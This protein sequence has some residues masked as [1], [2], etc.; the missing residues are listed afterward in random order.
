MKLTG[1]WASDW[2]FGPLAAE[3]GVSVPNPGIAN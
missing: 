1:V 2:R 3:M